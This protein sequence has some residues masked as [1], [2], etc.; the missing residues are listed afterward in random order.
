MAENNIPR[1]AKACAVTS[2]PFAPGDLFYSVLFEDGETGD[3]FGVGSVIETDGV[4]VKRLD[5]APEVWNPERI[6]RGEL[7]RALSENGEAPR[8]EKRN[9]REK[10]PSPPE[11][12]RTERSNEKEGEKRGKNGEG[13]EANPTEV[14]STG[15]SVS[16]K[17]EILGWWRSVVPPMGERKFRLAPNDILLDLFDHWNGQP[18]REEYLYILTLLMVRRRIFRF[19]K[20][21]KRVENDSFSE[22][23]DENAVREKKKTSEEEM[24]DGDQADS[25][26]MPPSAPPG[27]RE[28]IVYS[29]R[30]ETTYAV[31]VV[32]LDAERIAKIQES[33]AEILYSGSDVGGELS[34]DET[35]SA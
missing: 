22:N 25:L 7:P 21:E 1:P 4:K 13:D 15:N 3:S 29:P 33:L 12:F 34:S 8:R 27:K 6:A 9:L 20:E 35:I 28:I 32:S 31:E 11:N 30:R 18:G 24:A 5:Y 10:T 23:M 17:V 2:R 16:S 19:E 26:A 14:S